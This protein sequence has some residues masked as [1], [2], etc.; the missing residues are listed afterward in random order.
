LV[1]MLL[2]V[3][4]AM[5]QR[6]G[7]ERDAEVGR[8]TKRVSGQNSK[9]AGVRWHAGMDCNLHRKIRDVP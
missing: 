7:Y 6:E 5:Q 2:E 8:G 1:K 4:L 3:S 9:T